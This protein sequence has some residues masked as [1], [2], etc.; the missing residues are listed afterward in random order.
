VR[1]LPEQVQRSDAVVGRQQDQQAG[2]G[3]RRERLRQR[4][5]RYEVLAPVA[6]DV[7]PDGA[8]DAAAGRQEVGRIAL[9]G[10][11]TRCRGQRERHQQEQDGGEELTRQ[12]CRP[13]R[14]ASGR[15]RPA[16]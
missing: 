12:R 8:R 13:E 6:I 9:A 16:M 15:R 1:R 11:G 10:L 5:E 14:P 4:G 3:R 2:V 7:A